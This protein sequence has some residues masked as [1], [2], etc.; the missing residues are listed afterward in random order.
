[1]GEVTTAAAAAA[2]A[3]HHHHCNCDFTHKF[4]ATAS[5]WF[6]TPFANIEADR[7]S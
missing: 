3:H 6:Q 2:A 7:L 5:L 4:A 1:M